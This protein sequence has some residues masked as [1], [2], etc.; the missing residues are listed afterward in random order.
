MDGPIGELAYG[1]ET[2]SRTILH[3]MRFPQRQHSPTIPKWKYLK[4][5]ILGK[6]NDFICHCSLNNID[7]IGLKRETEC[8]I[9]AKNNCFTSLNLRLYT[10]CEISSQISENE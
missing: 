3:R 6:M 10:A 5:G 2:D 1:I 7:Y 9:D 8:P 4:F